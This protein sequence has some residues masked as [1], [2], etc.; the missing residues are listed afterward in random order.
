LP[1]RSWLAISGAKSRLS[2]GR[3]FDVEKAAVAGGAGGVVDADVRFDHGGI[4]DEIAK[5]LVGEQDEVGP[6]LGPEKGMRFPLRQ[7]VAGEPGGK[8]P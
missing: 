3:V 5:L 8:R 7:G 2:G 1:L 4:P 6:D